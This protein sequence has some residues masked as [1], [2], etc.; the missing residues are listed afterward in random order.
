MH[1]KSCLASA[2]ICAVENARDAADSD[3]DFRILMQE[4]AALSWADG[5]L[6][7]GTATCSCAP[8]VMKTPTGLALEM[9]T[10]DTL[11]AAMERHGLRYSELWDHVADVDAGFTVT[12]DD[13]ASFALVTR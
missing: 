8:Y 1:T 4:G 10:H 12:A 13:G 9:P 7:D 2:I 11:R 6:S 3:F 5:Y